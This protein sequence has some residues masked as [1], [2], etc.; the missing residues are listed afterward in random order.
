MNKEYPDYPYLRKLA[1]RVGRI[2]VRDFGTKGRLKSD[3]SVVTLADFE[4]NRKV[5]DAISHDYPEISIIGEEKS[6]VKRGSEYKVYCDPIDGTIPF[7]VLMPLSAFCISVLKN[8]EPIVALIYNPLCIKPQMWHAVKG[9][10]AF[11]N[12]IPAKVSELKT[13]SISTVCMVAWRDAPYNL[14]A[15]DYRLRYK[16]AKV[17]INPAAIACPGGLVASGYIEATVFAGKSDWEAGAMKLIVEEA[18]GKFTDLRGDPVM[19][20]RPLI[21][22]I[23][24]NGLVHDELLAMAADC[25]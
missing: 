14:G 2:I 15:M 13:L 24:S 6:R 12:G 20:G 4:I 16:T 11:L 3:G 17:S 1:L 22:H 10:G 21:G 25:L 5:I 18:G 9:K 19:L 7:S 8:K 23:A